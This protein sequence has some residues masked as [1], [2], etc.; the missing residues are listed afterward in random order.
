MSWISSMSPA[1]PGN[2]TCVAPEV[3]RL[4]RQLAQDAGKSWDRMSQYP[5]FERNEWRDK[6]ERM[7]HA[8]NTLDHFGGVS[9]S[10]AA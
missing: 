1:A 9:T 8:R 3:E 6:A 4:A 2:D 7:L 5:G 10:F